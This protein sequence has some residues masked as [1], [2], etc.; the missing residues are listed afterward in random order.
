MSERIVTANGL[1]FTVTDEGDGEAVVLL[2][3]FPDTRA[4][5]RRQIP[6][7]TRAGYRAIAPDM[8]GRGGSDKPEGIESYFAPLMLQDV[9]GIMDSLDVG[10][11]HLVGHDW[12]AVI[13]WLIAS[14]EPERVLSLTALSVGH[15]ASW[16]WPSVEQRQRSWYMAYFQLREAEDALRRDDWR[17]LREWTG[18]HPETAAHIEALT[19]DGA[20]TAGLNWYRANAVGGWFAD[21]LP[22]PPVGVPVMGVWSDGD[23]LLTEQQMLASNEHV[24]GR[25]RYERIEGASHWIPLDQPERINALLLEFLAE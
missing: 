11:A 16:A 4:L 22:Y 10:R 5:W 24:A 6:A 9:T 8:R 2:H 19:P 13:A 3:G 20:L 18:D 17:L 7:L 15:P 14:F 21:P 25:W 1:R 12:G 23:S